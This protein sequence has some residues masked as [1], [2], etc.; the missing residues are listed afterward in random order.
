VPVFTR[1]TIAA[2]ITSALL[3]GSTVAATPALA[4]D[5]GASAS[6]SH[7][8]KVRAW[9]KTHYG[10]FKTWRRSGEGDDLLTLPKSVKA[11][12]VQAHTDGES[13]FIVETLNS[14]NHQQDLLVNE[15]GT[16]SGTREFGLETKSKARRLKIT[17]DGE[18]TVVLKPVWKA[19][20][21]PKSHKGDGVYL[22]NKPA[23][24]LKLT[25]SGSS[26]F[27]VTQHTGGTYGWNLLA[28]EIGRYRGT[29]PTEG[30][31]S[32]IDVEADGRWTAHYR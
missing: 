13:N 22:F 21:L 3:L 20:A 11:A 1:M 18:W 24:A 19:S 17:A 8:S 25:H 9:A 7:T 10:T 14:K 12:I 6:T 27:I 30:G 28:N 4:A 32:V 15:I 29:V 2:A 23:G 31:P 5:A 26:N 16:Y